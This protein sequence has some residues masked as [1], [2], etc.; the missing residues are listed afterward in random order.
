MATALRP[1]AELLSDYNVTL[2]DSEHECEVFLA[3]R[4]PSTPSIVGLD[5]E[6]VN[7]D[8][9]DSAPV[10]LL[11]LAFSNNQCLLVRVFKMRALGLRLTDLLSNRR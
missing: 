6:W 5:C 7:R 4:L 8:N 10:A 2:V 9:V 3:E 1:I 11:Q